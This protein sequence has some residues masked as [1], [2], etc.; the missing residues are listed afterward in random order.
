MTEPELSVAIKKYSHIF[1]AKINIEVA[2][3]SQRGGPTLGSF[4]QSGP[5]LLKIFFKGNTTIFL[6]NSQKNFKISMFWNF[7]TF[8]K[9]LKILNFYI[10]Y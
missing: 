1:F 6:K 3:L 7:F 8:L 5:V 2:I 9:I 4:A 10:N